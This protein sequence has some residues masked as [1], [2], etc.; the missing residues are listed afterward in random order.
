MDFP[1][2]SERSEILDKCVD[3]HRKTL[4]LRKRTLFFVDEN[5]DPI[6]DILRMADGSVVPF[7]M[8]NY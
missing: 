1:L 2:E 7:T 6:N 3:H 5:D 8:G 4:R